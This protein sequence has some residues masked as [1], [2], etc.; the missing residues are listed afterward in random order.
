MQSN[1]FS[2]IVKQ[3]IA[4]AILISC[5]MLYQERYDAAGAIMGGAL[6]G[7]VNLACL[8]KLIESYVKEGG[9]FAISF[10][11]LVKFP[12]LYYAGYVAIATSFFPTIPLLI[13][14]SLVFLSIFFSVTSKALEKA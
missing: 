3:T 4:L 12:L 14:T 6:W 1:F 11:L 7:C 5:I 13:G 9:Y 8:K 2:V 10:I